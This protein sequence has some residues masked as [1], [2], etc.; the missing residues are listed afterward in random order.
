[1]CEGVDKT[2]SAG[3]QV[4]LKK[5]RKREREELTPAHGH[6]CHFK[7]PVVAIGGSVYSQKYT[8]PFDCSYA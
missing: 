1:M 6:A 8:F 3:R 7:K 4:D 2:F 5:G